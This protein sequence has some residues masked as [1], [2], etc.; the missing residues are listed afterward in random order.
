MSVSEYSFNSDYFEIIKF[1]STYYI[2]S[3]GEAANLFIPFKKPFKEVRE[4][5]ELD[6]TLSCEQTKC[7]DFLTKHK[8]SLLF[9]DT[10]S[11]KS[12]IYF[13]LFEDAINSGKT[14]IFLLPEISLTP[15]MT[16]RLKEKFG[17]MIAIWHSKVTKKK[18]TEIL[19]NIYSGKVKIV[20]GARS[21]L[22]LPL[23]DIGV[24]VVDEEHDDSYKSNSRPRYNARDMAIFM[25]RKLGAKVVLG[26]ATPS[27][28]S[29]KKYP[30]YR[31][32]ETF[33][34]ASRSFNFINNSNEITQY[35]K[36]KLAYTLSSN[37]QA[38]VFLP[39][40]ANYKYLV[41]LSCG[42]GIK[43]PF[44]SVGMSLHHKINALKC[45]YCNYSQALPQVCPS[46]KK[47]ELKASRLG[48]AQVTKELKE[49]FLEK[50]IAQFDRDTIKTPTVLKNILKEF[51]NKEIDLLVGT[52]MLSKGHDYH[53]VKLV[54][55]FD[56]DTVLSM[57]DFRSRQRA[58]SLLIQ[59]AGR[60]GRKGEGKVIV[61]SSNQEFFEG[62]L[63]DY[64]DFL[65][66]ELLFC[67]DLYPPYKKLLKL[68]IAHKDK[69]KGIA[70][71]EKTKNTLNQI[72]N[73]DVEIV[74]YGDAPI[75]K[76][77]NKYR[78]QILLRS[79]SSSSLIKI[80]HVLNITG[81]EIDIDPINFS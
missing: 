40:R 4:S 35:I 38:I 77:A 23:R 22:F 51:N 1:L 72:K 13:K 30:C 27:L 8:V 33:F 54:V 65:K 67:K 58:L 68:L 70:L 3:F 62:Y 31:L 81:V 5:I 42:E 80:A 11:G 7:Y 71:L 78:F 18:K 57:A 19:E 60:V 12:E 53:G 52:Q 26:S 48:T 76:I 79:S 25:G 34:K 46:C 43:C 16:K 32:K 36:D 20:M 2:C 49:E 66:D 63:E 28:T 10:G 50:N 55:I 45:H 41:C 74:G 24:I 14:C 47:S 73:D 9:G 15:Q 39:T 69:D 59:V 64:E 21:S 29:Y 44:C 17:D 56:I 61:Q 6:M 37:H 75:E